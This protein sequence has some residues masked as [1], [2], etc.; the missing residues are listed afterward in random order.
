MVQHTLKGVKQYPA[1]LYVKETWL[2]N[3]SA[4]TDEASSAFDPQYL[5]KYLGSMQ[6]QTKRNWFMVKEQRLTTFVLLIFQR[7]SRWKSKR[8]RTT[9]KRTLETCWTICSGKPRPRPVYTG[10][11]SLMS[12]CVSSYPLPSLHLIS[13]ALPA[14]L[15][16]FPFSP[17]FSVAR[18]RVLQ[19]EVI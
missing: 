5:L 7:R 14:C 12:R 8:R 17:P 4:D 2:S 9:I 11:H 15:P 1:E 3:F 13:Y 18:A 10:Y 6:G 19:T 16:P